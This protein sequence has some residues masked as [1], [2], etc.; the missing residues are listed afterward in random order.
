MSTQQHPLLTLR[1]ILANIGTMMMMLIFY[2]GP[3]P[4]QTVYVG[5]VAFRNNCLLR[6][7]TDV[8]P[9]PR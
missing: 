5:Y 3:L 8:E 4:K 1:T 6:C 2:A 9:G 7:L